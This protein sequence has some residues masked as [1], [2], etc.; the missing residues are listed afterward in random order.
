MKY[1][2]LVNKEHKIKENFLNRINLV[3]IKDFE[4]KTHLIEESIR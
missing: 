4:N 1:K 2:V 3:E